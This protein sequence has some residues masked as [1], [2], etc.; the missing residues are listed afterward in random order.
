MQ[1]KQRNLGRLSEIAQVAVRHGFGYFFRRHRLTDLLPWGTAVDGSDEDTVMSWPHLVVR[2]LLLLEI[3]VIVLALLFWAT[4]VAD[5]FVVMSLRVGMR[6]FP[7]DRTA[8]VAGIGS[9]S[10]SAVQA[11]VLPIYGQWVDLQWYGII[12]GT[13]S[14]LPIIGTSLWF[15][16][17]RKD[18]L[19]RKIPV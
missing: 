10:W 8:M 18:E 6:I 16:L 13:M 4:F 3:M 17:S 14:L 5:G 2:E 12:F 11:I 7:S 19:W 9:G 1:S 15:W